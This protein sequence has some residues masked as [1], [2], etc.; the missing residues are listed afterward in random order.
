VTDTDRED[1]W[2]RSAPHV[3]AALVRRYGDF[4]AAEDA[5]QEALL[6]ASLQWSAEGTPDN[7]TAWLIRVAS[8][9]LVDRLRSDTA[10][11]DREQAAATQV[12]ADELHSPA[13]DA[14]DGAARDDTVLLLLL[15][16]HPALMRASQVA[17]TLRAVG[18][19]T[20]AQIARAFLVPESTMGQRISR[21][22][23]RL[24]EVGAGFMLPT[25]EDLPDR[26]ASLQHVLYLIFNEGYTS[27]D[28]ATLY[29]VSLTDEAI[30]LTRQL[31]EQLPSSD[32][33]AG[34]LALM[35]LT[36]ARRSARAHADGSLVPLAIQDRARWDRAAIA[37]GT[38]LLETVLPRGHVGPYQLQ[39]AIAAVHSEAKSWEETDWMQI[40]ILYRMLDDIVP[41]PAVTLNL[42][43]AVAMVHR[44]DAGLRM[45]DPLV[46]E[47]HMRHNHRIHAVRAHLLEMTGRNDEARAAFAAAARLTT[48]IPEQR[49][50]NGKAARLD[51]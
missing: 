25:P 17:L 12:P 34:L 19:L 29:D 43:V 32:E 28:G 23:A 14:D 51:E 21:A 7:P 41:S 44:P 26:M 11:A 6:A 49:Y 35:L 36:D 46:D 3:L 38:G 2:R 24:R 42:A 30:R 20:T 48:S 40:L 16:C 10:R 22:K 13:A 47:T 4:D 50:L 15:C 39:A 33:V 18:G 31:H 9:R 37:E 5:V 45:L 8:R 27:T 1:M